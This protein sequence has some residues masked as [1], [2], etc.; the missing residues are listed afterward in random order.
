MLQ[1][2]KKNSTERPYLTC[3]KVLSLISKQE[4]AILE[5]YQDS[6]KERR[7]NLDRKLYGPLLPNA[8]VNDS[9]YTQGPQQQSDFLRADN[10][11]PTI[12][13]PKKTWFKYQFF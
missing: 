1:Q 2:M 9:N 8:S 3:Y 5:A 12:P 7:E 11:E 4:V 10:V 6:R 13:P